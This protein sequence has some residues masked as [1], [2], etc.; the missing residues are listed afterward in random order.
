MLRNKS[1]NPPSNKWKTV[2]CCHHTDLGSPAHQVQQNWHRD[3]YWIQDQKPV[4]KTEESTNGLGNRWS[5]FWDHYLHKNM[6]VELQLCICLVKLDLWI[7][8]KYVKL[9]RH[10]KRLYVGFSSTS[11]YHWRNKWLTC[12][13]ASMLLRSLVNEP[14]RTQICDKL[15][16]LATSTLGLHTFMVTCAPLYAFPCMYAI[17]CCFQFTPHPQSTTHPQDVTDCHFFPNNC[18]GSSTGFRVFLGSSTDKHKITSC[19]LCRIVAELGFGT[20]DRPPFFFL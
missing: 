1:M 13:P 15:N 17:A 5:N 12:Q 8:L 18:A 14:A 6:L 3:C 19:E 2:D 7:H 10:K 9:L 16:S 11:P 4:I 20:A